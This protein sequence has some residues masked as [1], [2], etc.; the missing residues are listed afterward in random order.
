MAIEI[1]AETLDTAQHSMLLIPENQ[2]HTEELMAFWQMH[3]P[4]S[5]CSKVQV[6]LS[7]FSMNQAPRH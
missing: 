1:F 4:A 6:K 3:L 5:L 2:N 7:L